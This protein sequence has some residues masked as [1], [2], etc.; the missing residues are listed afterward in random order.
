[1]NFF[2][3]KIKMKKSPSKKSKRIRRS[4]NTKKKSPKRIIRKENG[5][6]SGYIYQQQCINGKC[7]K[8]E[9]HINNL[10][11]LEKLLSRLMM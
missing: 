8:F 2:I 6:F 1:M 7:N 10:N 3:Y 5:Q 4:R 9:K 11:E